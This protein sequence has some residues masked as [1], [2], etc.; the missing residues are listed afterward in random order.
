MVEFIHVPPHEIDNLPTEAIKYLSDAIR[1][2]PASTSRLDI[3][4]DM[5]RKG[6]G[7]IYLVKDADA[8]IGA[9]NILVYDTPEGRIVSPFLVGGIRMHSW[10]A[11]LK[12]FTFKF[13]ESINAI[14]IRCIARKGWN[15]LYPMG[16]VV[17]YV[18]DYPL[19]REGVG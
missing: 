3:T 10:A 16:K 17:G 9:V 12:D 2:T 8:L 14:A 7:D 1:R 15:K 11:A 18:Y 19:N 13:C 6:Y 4:L 5:A